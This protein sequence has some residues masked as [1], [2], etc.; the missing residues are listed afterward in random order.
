MMKGRQVQPQL[1]VKAFVSGRELKMASVKLHGV[2][3]ESEADD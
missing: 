3:G 2:G 1:Q